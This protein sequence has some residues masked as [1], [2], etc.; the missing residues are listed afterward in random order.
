M[1]KL[2]YNE[3]FGNND[4]KSVSACSVQMHPSLSLIGVHLGLTESLSA[5]LVGA[6]D[7]A[8]ELLVQIEC[9]VSYKGAK[10]LG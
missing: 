9:S 6:E 8:L 2:F 4:K 1:E 7:E 5:E 10:A 3:M